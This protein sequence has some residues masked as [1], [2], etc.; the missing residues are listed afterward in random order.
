MLGCHD[1]AVERVVILANLNHTQNMQ[2]YRSMLALYSIVYSKGVVSTQL[3][4][5]CLQE[6]RDA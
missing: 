5:E 3:V 4:C 6:L 2:R 1:T